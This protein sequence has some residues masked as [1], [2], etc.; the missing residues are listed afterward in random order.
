MLFRSYEDAEMICDLVFNEDGFVEPKINTNLVPIREFPLSGK[1]NM[2]TS[3][4]VVIW[5]HPETD[6]SGKVPW[7]RYLAGNDP[8]SQEDASR[9]R[10]LGSIFIFDKMSNTLVAEYTGRPTTLFEFYE[11]CRK[12]L[13]YYNAQCLYENMILGMKQHF[14]HKNS[15]QYLMFQPEYIK[16]I[17]PGSKVDRGYGMHMVEQLRDHGLL[18]I[19][20]WLQDEYEPGKI[21]RAHV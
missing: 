4:A 1:S 10:Y 14:E 6:D 19:R 21:G 11:R 20:D 9:Q 8:Y 16:D 2:D 15:L 3:G 13:I 18:L 12:L 5:H 17:I 7:G